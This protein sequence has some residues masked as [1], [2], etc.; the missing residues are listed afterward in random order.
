MGVLYEHWRPDTNECFYV[1]VSW[2]DEDNRPYDMDKRHPKHIDVQLELSEKG[3]SPEVRI[4]AKAD[5]LTREVLCE[6]EP[7]QIKYWK[8]L[9]GDRLIN[10]AKGGEGISIDWTD[11]LKARLSEI[12]TDFYKTPEGKQAI[13]KS[14]E[15]N[16]GRKQPEGWGEKSIQW[17]LGNKSR[18]GMLGTRLGHTTPLE[19]RGKQSESATL[20]MSTE[21]GKQSASKGGRKGSVAK[22]GDTEGRAQMILDFEGSIHDCAAKFGVSISLVRNIR[23]RKTWRHLT[24]TNS[25]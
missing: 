1:G 20:R 15:K 25:I 22:W 11:E 12:M 23:N 8:D 19:V 10:I 21:E 18:T 2:A 17:K 4:Q 5:W 13:E 3:L 14:R 6:I 16:T 9:I 7:L 24:P